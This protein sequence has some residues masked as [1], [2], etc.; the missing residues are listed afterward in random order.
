MIREEND[1]SNKLKTGA[2]AIGA[3]IIW[4]R[5]PIKDIREYPIIA[6]VRNDR[7]RFERSQGIV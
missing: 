4:P 3:A 2:D 6:F 1:M 5:D 7:Q